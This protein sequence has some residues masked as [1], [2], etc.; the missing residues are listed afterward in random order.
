MTVVVSQEGIVCFV[1]I[2][3]LSFKGQGFMPG[4]TTIA[5]E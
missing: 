4:S 5:I 3:S 2:L 1:L